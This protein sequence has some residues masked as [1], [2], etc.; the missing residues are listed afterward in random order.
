LHILSVF[1][2]F[3]FAYAATHMD[4]T[5]QSRNTMSLT[6]TWTWTLRLGL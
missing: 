6:Q 2:A 1:C 5:M 3:M 4:E